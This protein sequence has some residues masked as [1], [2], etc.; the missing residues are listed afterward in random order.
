LKINIRFHIYKFHIKNYNFKQS[1]SF[2]KI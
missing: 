2:I 1:Y